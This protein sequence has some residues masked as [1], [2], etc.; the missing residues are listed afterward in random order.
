MKHRLGRSAL[1]ALSVMTTLTTGAA[2]VAAADSSSVP[3][4][5]VLL[6]SVDGLH[7]NDL[8]M[9]VA[10]HPT[11]ALARLAASG[12]TY[13]DASTST[14]SDSF[15]GLLAE[16]TGGSPKSTGVY[17]DVT[18]DNDLSPAGS[19][20]STR[21]ALVPFNQSINVD[22][23]AGGPMSAAVLPKLL[24]RHTLWSQGVAGVMLALPS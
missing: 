15:P 2:V 8:A 16:V 10:E 21:G 5:H 17:Y 13:T 14:P 19:D 9:W 3:A 12:T 23:N 18:W 24:P 4:R 6:I 1:V 7:A 11:S 20:C 22:P